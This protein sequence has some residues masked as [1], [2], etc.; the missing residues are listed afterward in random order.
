M[1][2][3][4]YVISLAHDL[5]CIRKI[6]L[7]AQDVNLLPNARLHVFPSLCSFMTSSH[8]AHP[9]LD[10]QG[11]QKPGTLLNPLREVHFNTLGEEWLI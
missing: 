2:G 7:I 1:L 3:K 9:F 11:K 4:P 6:K 5:K 10:E 8:P